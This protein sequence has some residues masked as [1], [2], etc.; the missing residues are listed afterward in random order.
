MSSTAADA[1]T[2][3]A[4]LAERPHHCV[5]DN[6]PY[7]AAEAQ[8]RKEEHIRPVPARGSIHS[9]A[10]LSLLGCVQLG[11]LLLIGYALFLLLARF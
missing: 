6:A 11:W 2:D 5:D 1:E 7:R 9:A 3:R 8:A 10:V 4:A